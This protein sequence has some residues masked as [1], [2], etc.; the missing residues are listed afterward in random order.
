MITITFKPKTMELEITGHASHGKKG[1]D[2]VCSA[3]STLFYTLGETLYQST[4]MLTAM[5]IVK[6]ENGVGYIWSNARPQYE[7]NV[8]MMYMT[9]LNGLQM[10]AE[11]YPKNVQLEIKE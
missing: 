1:E 10:V 2:I 5:P 6:T 8:Q 9:V 4:E 11:H 7:G 3:V